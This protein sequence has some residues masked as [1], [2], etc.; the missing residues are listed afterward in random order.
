LYGVIV[1]QMT[2]VQNRE[3]WRSLEANELLRRHAEA[4]TIARREAEQASRAKSTFLANISHELRTP[5]HGI[6]SYARFGVNRVG[7]VEDEKLVEYFERIESS[8]NG[9]LVLFDDLLDLSR[10]EA[11]RMA[12][13][14]EVQRLAPAV[15]SVVDEFRGRCL[16]DGIELVVDIP[17]PSCLAAIDPIRFKQ[18]IRNLLSNALRYA[19]DSSTLWVRQSCHGE[20]L[21]IEVEDEGPGIPEA[22]LDQIFEKFV[23]SSATES[24]AGGTGLGLTISRQLMVLQNGTI[25]AENR[26]EGG[27]RFVAQ[28]PRAVETP[29]PTDEPVPAEV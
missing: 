24:G 5:L 7:R 1:S 16:E 9:L 10:L 3:Y 17:D 23:Q 22:E 4:L 26:D 12:C 21:S 11:G 2:R 28:V 14:P 19:P 15:L 20:T 27:A 29:E 13:H 18:V 6:L 25:R 8:G